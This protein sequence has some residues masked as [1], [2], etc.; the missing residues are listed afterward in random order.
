MALLTHW[1]EAYFPFITRKHLY[2]YLIRSWPPGRVCLVEYKLPALAPISGVMA[3]G[4]NWEEERSR[5]EICNQAEELT[6]LREVEINVIDIE[7]VPVSFLHRMVEDLLDE[8]SHRLKPKMT[9][10]YH[11]RF[12]KSIQNAYIAMLVKTNV[13]ESCVTSPPSPLF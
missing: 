4:E 5:S 1:D 3:W 2:L 9:P 13:F 10:L 7:V 11:V 6:I 12:V 8:R